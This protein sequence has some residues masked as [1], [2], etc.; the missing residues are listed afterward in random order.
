MKWFAFLILMVP[1]LAVA[2]IEPEFYLCS[3]YVQQ[4]AV[5]ERNAQG[6]PVYV[7][8]TDAGAASFARFTRDNMGSLSRIM[9][10]GRPFL[11]ATIQAPIVGGVLHGEFSSLEVAT[12]WQIMLSTE[13]PAYPCGAN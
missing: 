3:A 13:L 11:E 6:W 12:A 4:S 9:A 8:L 1:C 2:E 5:G 7:K 10:D